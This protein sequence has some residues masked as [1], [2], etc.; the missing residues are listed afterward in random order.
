MN[1]IIT[2][3]SLAL[4]VLFVHVFASPN[5]GQKA[6][7]EKERSYFDFLIGEWRVEKSLILG[8]VMLGGDDVYKFK[9][10][11]NGNAIV[12]EWYINRGTKS[13]P[14]YANALYFSGFDNSTGKWSFYYISHKSAHFYESRKENGEWYFYRRFDFNGE[15]ILQRQKITPV[16]EN[17]ALRKIENSKDNGKTWELIVLVTL[18]KVR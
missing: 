12:A 14:D 6:N 5:F 17:T 16:D 13:N 7:L 11:L 4:L 3:S 9:K 18:K 1:K 8:E 2:S 10:D 15:E